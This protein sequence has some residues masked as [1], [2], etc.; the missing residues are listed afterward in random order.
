MSTVVACL[1]GATV[2][3]KFLYPGQL[4]LGR[5]IHAPSRRR[6]GGV[7]RNV[8]ANIAGQGLTAILFSAVGDDDDGRALIADAQELRID[9]RGIRRIEG[10][11][12]GRYVAVVASDGEIAFAVA[13]T[14]IFECESAIDLEDVWPVAVDGGWVFVETNVRADVI[15]AVISRRKSDVFRVALD[16]GS[17]PSAT[18][19]PR[20]L[21][22]VDLVFMNVDEAAAYFAVSSMDAADAARGLIAR[23]AASA[24]VTRGALGCVVADPAIVEIAALPAIPK[25]RTGAGDALIGGTLSALIGGAPLVKAVEA[26]TALAAITIETM[27]S[28]FRTLAR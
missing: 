23:G 22:G 5:E 19:L 27:E 26:G 12:T 8:A 2:D 10:A 7:A 9:T 25:D 13:D 3:L 24:V 1:G 18:K 21:D 28:F 17:V 11:Q 20:S 4:L 15:A 16:A 6:F 14:A